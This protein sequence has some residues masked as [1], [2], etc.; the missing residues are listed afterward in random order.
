MLLDDAMQVV[1][2]WGGQTNNPAL[3]NKTFLNENDEPNYSLK[4]IWQ[5][6]TPLCHICDA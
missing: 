5:K 1:D 2:Y 6:C 3:Y 4:I